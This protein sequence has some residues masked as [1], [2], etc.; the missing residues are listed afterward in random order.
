MT[1]FDKRDNK[2]RLIALLEEWGF[3]L[4]GKKHSSNGEELVYLR[5]FEPLYNLANPKS[6]YPFISKRTNMFLV[7]IYPKY[8]TELLPDSILRE[9]V[10]DDFDAISKAFI[11]RSLETGLNAGDLIIFY[12][13]GGLYKSVISTVGIVEKIILDIKN[14][15]DFISK[16]RNRSIFTDD[17]L[18]KHWNYNKALRPFIVNF[19][20]AYSFPKRITL[21]DL[22]DLC[23]ITDIESTPRGFHKISSEQFNLIIRETKSDARLIV[24]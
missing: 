24:D 22:I 3:V 17:E 10:T 21:K 9:E 7:P 8:H 18:R 16:C 6:T 15:N 14:E 1:L 11:S 19:L 23:I 5:N 12:R 13:T 4:Y 20:Y 2:K